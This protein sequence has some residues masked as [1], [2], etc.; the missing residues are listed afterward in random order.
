MARSQK[1]IDAVSELKMWVD[2]EPPE[3]VH[4]IF[5][6]LAALPGGEE[7]EGIAE[8]APV[9]WKETEML[10]NLLAN[11]GDASDVEYATEEL[12]GGDDE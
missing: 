3:F 2:S 12:M 1:L 4:L 6:F 11:L 5:S 10:G 8:P 7:S 9:G